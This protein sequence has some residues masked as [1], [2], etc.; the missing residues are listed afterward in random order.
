MARS[1]TIC[2][3][4]LAKCCSI[5]V[6]YFALIKFVVFVLECWARETGSVCLVCLTMYSAITRQ[7][8]LLK[9]FVQQTNCRAARCS[10]GFLAAV[11]NVDVPL[12]C[13]IGLTERR[14]EE[15]LTCGRFKHR[16][17]KV[18]AY[19]GNAGRGP[20]SKV[21]KKTESWRQTCWS[22]IERWWDLHHH[23]ESI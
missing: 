8:H 21:E 20:E 19:V 11:L 2:Q 23:P 17:F 22:M 18:S 1:Q 7:K 4:D 14:G 5:A 9:Q 6:F 12:S 10:C 16:L 13:S 15:D 3:C